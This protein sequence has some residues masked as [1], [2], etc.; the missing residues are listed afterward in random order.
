MPL[1]L[2]RKKFRSRNTFV[3]YLKK[4]ELFCLYS[5]LNVATQHYRMH[6]PTTHKCTGS[7]IQFGKTTISI[8]E[9][10]L[11]IHV[12]INFVTRSLPNTAD[13]LAYVHVILV[14]NDFLV[15]SNGYHIIQ[16]P[17]TSKQQQKDAYPCAVE[18]VCN[19]E[20]KNH[21]NNG[22]CDLKK[23]TICEQ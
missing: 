5:L 10:M 12:N 2:R 21:Q 19:Q 13:P 8:T 9:H 20:S 14:L 18:S 16:V 23:I 22:T 1:K 6:N 7:T 11:N 4:H 17:F 15:A 3:S